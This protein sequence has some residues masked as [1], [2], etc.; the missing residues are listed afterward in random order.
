MDKVRAMH[1]S[2]WDCKQYMYSSAYSRVYWQHWLSARKVCCGSTVRCELLGHTLF[3]LYVTV[4][5]VQKI[6]HERSAF[7]VLVRL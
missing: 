4:V 2:R 3:A 1:F 6:T 5:I 7:G